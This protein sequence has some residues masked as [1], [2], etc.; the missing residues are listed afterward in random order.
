MSKQS[1]KGKTWTR[2]AAKIIERDGGQCLRCG[3]CD[4]LTVDHI[5][6]LDAMSEEDIEDGLPTDPSNLQTLCRRCNGRKS[7][8]PD[9]QRRTWL[10]PNWLEGPG[11]FPTNPG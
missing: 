11:L 10:N 8:R 6:P 7:N 3:S 2:L 9:D 5:I 4:D 1:L